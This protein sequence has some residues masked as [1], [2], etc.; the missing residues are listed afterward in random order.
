VKKN[1]LM[2]G[3]LV[4]LAVAAPDK[5]I[6]D[7][8]AW[9]FH[10][11][12]ILGT[13]LD[14]TAV[15]PDEAMAIAAAEAV[16]AEI[17]R[18]D[19]ILSG[20]RDDS[21]LA[22]VNRGTETRVSAELFNVLRSAARWRVLTKGAFDERLGELERLWRRAALHGA[23]GVNRATLHRAVAALSEPVEPCGDNRVVRRAQGVRLALDGF[24]KGVIIDAALDAARRAAP[25]VEGLMVDVGGDLRCWGRAPGPDGWSIGVAHPLYVADNAAPLAVMKLR[26]KAV[27]TSGRSDRDHA[28]AG[29]TF[30]HLLDPRSGQP[31]EGVAGVTVVA[32]LAADADALATAFSAMPINDSLSLAD[33]LPCVAA[34][35]TLP[36]GSQR[37]S[38][39]WSAWT[40]GIGTTS[41]QPPV[42]LAQTMPQQTGGGWPSGYALAIQ[43]EVPEIS[44]GRY[45][46]PYLAIWVT[47]AK[48]RA[49][50]TI[51]LLGRRAGWQR[52]NYLWSR[53]YA[54]EASAM[55][56]ATSRPTR[57]PGRYTAVWDGRDHAGRPLPQGVYTIHV[58]AVREYGGHSY[59][60]TNLELFDRV[61]QRDVRPR[62]EFGALR[63]NY[64]PAR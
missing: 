49:V 31:V 55:V 50:R 27:A 63:F 23:E 24:A 29:Q 40:A 34:S 35:I 47:D 32:D 21:E 19:S 11:D 14:V 56:D 16:R 2:A 45:R 42:L 30:S 25:V 52:G 17:E 8:A 62:E 15:A 54:G 46:R 48:G 43:Y 28:V 10:A 38:A 44:G 13:S 4:A 64:G 53:L 22:S 3:S 39:R 5:A 59:G 33:R 58:E 57:A 12:H 51:L 1:L 36:D 37:M 7:V 6:A 9:R 60:S 26:D 61:T 18:L 20:W 41:M